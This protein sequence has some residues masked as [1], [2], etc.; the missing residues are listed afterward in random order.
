MKQ[1]RAWLALF[2]GFIA[3]GGSAPPLKLA[4]KGQ[5]QSTAGAKADQPLLLAMGWYPSF[6]GTAPGAPAAAVLTQDNLS[7]S[8]NFPVDFTFAFSGPPPAAAL[9]DL[10]KTGGKGHLAYGVLIAFRDLNG[11]KSLDSISA[12][13]AKV[14]DI[15][16]ISVPDPSLPPPEH[17]FFVLYLDGAVAPD[18]VYAAQPLQQG[19]NLMEIHYDFGVEPVPI[20][21]SI[22][23]PIANDAAVNLYA[24]PSAFQTP[25]FF[26]RACGIDPYAGK[27]ILQGNVFSLPAAAQ[28]QFFVND[29]DGPVTNA[30]LT[31]DGAPVARDAAGQDYPFTAHTPMTGSHTLS[32]AVPGFPVETLPFTLPDPVLLQAP[33]NGQQFTSGAPVSISWA[34]VLGT[35][36]YDIYFIDSNGNWLFHTITNLTAVTT[37]PIVFQ[38]SARLTVKALGALAVGSL[39]SF[40]TPMSQTSVTLTFV[41]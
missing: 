28:A 19:Y 21:T 31:L 12:S 17:S 3:C 7:F 8:G 40:V 2:L 16:G 14:D 24:C 26:Q 10:S 25:G 30:T 35:A 38:G 34:G 4:L 36:Y 9:F 39:G 11:N 22:T 37:L 6:A 23:I 27:A 18:D 5:L 13:G 20:D 41:H 29:A 33:A 1:Q 15:A 32:I